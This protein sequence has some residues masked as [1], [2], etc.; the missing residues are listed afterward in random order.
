VTE[1]YTSKTCSK[2]GQVHNKL[3]G[4]KVFKCPNPD[5]QNVMDR[6]KNGAFNIMLKALRDTSLSQ[7]KLYSVV[8]G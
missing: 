5:C 2:C 8:F 4:N 6:D 1:E 3:G 7:D